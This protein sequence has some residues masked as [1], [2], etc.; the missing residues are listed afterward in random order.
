LPAEDSAQS[1][2]RFGYL[3]GLAAG[4]YL[5]EAVLSA[6]AKDPPEV[7]AMLLRKTIDSVKLLQGALWLGDRVQVRTT[8]NKLAMELSAQE[9]MLPE[10]WEKTSGG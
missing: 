1:P 5:L 2:V 8:F 10:S 4:L 3:N 6:S 7:R 9:L